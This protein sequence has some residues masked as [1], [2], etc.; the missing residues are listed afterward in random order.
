MLWRSV[1]PLLRLTLAGF[2]DNAVNSVSAAWRLADSFGC[3]VIT[4]EHL[5][6]G[7]AEPNAPWSR[8]DRQLGR[9]RSI[10]PAAL[11]ILKAAK[12]EARRTG[13]HNVATEHIAVA[14][15]ADGS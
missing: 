13:C 11:S 6:A 1:I 7:L 3:P 15:A 14:L 9:C 10:G 12:N 2:T 8:S 4:P 5:R